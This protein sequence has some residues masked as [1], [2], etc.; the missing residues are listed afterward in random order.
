MSAQ[1]YEPLYAVPPFDAQQL[2]FAW[3]LRARRAAQRSLDAARSAPRKAAGYLSRVAVGAHLQQVPGWVQRLAARVTAP[4][5]GLSRHLGRT[6]LLAAAAGLVTSPL[7]RA[8]L[9]SATRLAGRGIGWSARKAYSGLDK[10]L[11]CLG[12]VGDAVADKLFLAVF[13]FGGKIATV[14]GP[15]VHRVARVSNPRTP[16]ARLLAA[17]CQ[18]YVM[19]KLLKVFVS[20]KW[21]RALMELVLVPA[22]LDSRLWIR[23]GVAVGQTRARAARLREQ[24]QVLVDLERQDAA[25]GRTAVHDAS[26]VEDPPP[27]DAS[28]VQPDDALSKSAED[29]QPS[30]RAERRAAQRQGKRTQH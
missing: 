28:E 16:Q 30:N 23:L 11:R 21:M 6:G 18:S 27:T 1:P 29:L 2:R 5:N 3:L 20:R 13:S 9:D 7:T 17:V 24:A 26:V 8:L 15:V 14:A 10:G 4:L 19:H 22:L 25:A 12:P